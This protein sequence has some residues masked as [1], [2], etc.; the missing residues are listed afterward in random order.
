M[1]IRQGDLNN[2]FKLK[3][4]NKYLDSL[5]DKNTYPENKRKEKNLY[6]SIKR[7]NKGRDIMSKV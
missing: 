6:K 5:I 2:H 3:K 7:Y 4:E 1:S